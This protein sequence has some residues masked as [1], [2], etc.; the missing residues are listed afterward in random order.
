MPKR[1]TLETPGIVIEAVDKSFRIVAGRQFPTPFWA[2]DCPAEPTTRNYPL[3]LRLGAQ[4][5]WVYHPGSA[6]PLHGVLT[7]CPVSPASTGPVT[8]SYALQVPAARI[9]QT[10]GGRVSFV[11]EPSGSS[12]PYADGSFD[13][14]AWVL[15]LSEQPFG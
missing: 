5:V 14:P 2:Y 1:A 13:L 8:Q 10:S 4:R 3:A 12:Q 9:E 15:W 7:F 11:M 6:R